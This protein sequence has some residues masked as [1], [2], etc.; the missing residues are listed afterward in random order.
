MI[1]Y[2]ESKTNKPRFI[3]IRNRSVARGRGWE[4]IW[5]MGVRRY[6]LPVVNNYWNVMYS[7]VTIVNNPIVWV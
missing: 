7:M 1:L 2:V 6:K 3:D 4:E 5:V